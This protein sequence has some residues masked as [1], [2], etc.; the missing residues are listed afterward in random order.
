MY[1][2]LF[3]ALC[4]LAACDVPD[5]PVID[6]GIL[7]Q[8]GRNCYENRC[9]NLN[10]AAGQVQMFGRNPARIPAGIAYQDGVVTADDFQRMFAAANAAYAQGIGRR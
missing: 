4:V 8:D 7:L 3:V 2:I 6:Q 10:M 9:F 5:N 1:R